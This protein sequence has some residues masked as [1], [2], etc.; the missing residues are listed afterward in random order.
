MK[1]TISV[2]ISLLFALTVLFPIGF[3]LSACFGY[4]FELGSVPASSAAIALL[5][6]CMLILDLIFKATIENKATQVLFSILPPLAFI[7][8]VFYIFLC[9]RIW[10]I[11]SVWVSAGCCCFLAVKHGKPVALRVAALVLSALMVLPVGFCSFIALIFGNIGQNTV[12]QTVASPSGTYYAQVI[13]SDQG[14]LGGDTFVDVYE[15]SGVDV[16]LFKTEK[17]PQRVYVGDWG[18]FANMQIHWKNDDCLV[19][20]S[21]EYKIGK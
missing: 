1:R 19:I 8:A 7:N 15:K 4:N 20:N 9:S 17:A 10:V 6:V 3:I 21:E 2:L 11:A 5:S 13:D 16:I 12:V 14:A 18:E